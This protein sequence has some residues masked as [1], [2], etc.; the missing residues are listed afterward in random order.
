MAVNIGTKQNSKNLILNIAA[1]VVQF[2]IGFYISPVIVGKVGASAYG[3]ISLANDFVSYAGI[4]AN[5]FNSVASRFIANEYY[6]KNISDANAYFSSLF[7]T[8]LILSFIF[9]LIGTV[10]VWN[11]DHV[12]N[13]PDNLV[14]D[15]KITF[16]L[17]FASYLVSLATNVFTTSTYV[18]N[19]TDLTGQREIIKQILRFILILI[20]LNFVSVR[21]YWVALATLFAALIVAISNIQF[22]KRLTPDLKIRLKNAN[23][24]YVKILAFSGFWMSFINISNLL[25]RGLDLTIANAMISADAMGLLSVARTIPN[26]FSSAIGTIAPIFTPVFILCFAKNKTE[27]LVARV[28]KSIKAMAL[29]FYVP[30]CGFLV[31]SR[32][33]YTLWQNDLSEKEII[34]ITALSSITVIQALFNSTTATLAQLSVVVNKLKLPVF[35]SFGCGVVNICVVMILLKTTNLGVYGIVI[36]ST[37]IMLLRYILFNSYYAAKILKQPVKVFLF[38]ELKTWATIPVIIAVCAIIKNILTVDSWFSLILSAA[39]AGVISYAAIA[40]MLFGKDCIKMAKNVLKR[41]K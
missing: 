32:D 39:V 3:F 13:V 27:E 26:N 41:K 7:V 15:V 38:Q 29:I 8:N 11:V 20:L 19:R 34:A 12:L 18:T 10:F 40:F 30:V 5:V 22:T 28:K 36:S 17:I 1:F 24:K 33:F 35:V 14:F 25:M 4:I 2:L 23:F 21:I 6:K 16:S 31:Y 9:C 37:I